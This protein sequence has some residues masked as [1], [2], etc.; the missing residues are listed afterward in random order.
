MLELPAARIEGA[1]YN[2]FTVLIPDSHRSEWD[3]LQQAPKYVKSGQLYIKAGTPRKPRTTGYRS[4]NSHIHGHAQQ[5]AEHAGDY[6]DD[7]IIHAKMR[8]VSHG[9]PTR[10]TMFGDIVPISEKEA[11]TVEAGYIIDELHIIASFANV[12]LKEYDE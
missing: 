10:K 12:K 6:K 2:A 1:T 3:V 7:I 8:A 4:Q 9:Y 5:I 11:S